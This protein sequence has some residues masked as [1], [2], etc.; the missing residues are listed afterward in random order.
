[1][2]ELYRWLLALPPQESTFASSIDKLHYFVITVTMLGATLVTLVGGVFILLYKR[3]GEAPPTEGPQAALLSAGPPSARTPTATVVI[4]TWLEVLVVGGLL[5][6]FLLWSIL[7]F[8]QFVHLRV[9]PEDALEVH[10]TGKKWMWQ[11]AYPGGKRSIS[12]LYV[13]AGRP[14]KLLM[15]SRDVIHSFFVPD[16]RAKWD[17]LPG[18]Y[19]TQWFEAKR[20]G[21]YQVLCTEYCGE[22]HSTMRGAVVALAPEEYDAWQRG[23]DT[24]RIPGQH[25]VEPSVVGD[26][27]E[28]QPI[29]M[30]DVGQRLAAEHGCLR[31]H[32]VDGSP[33]IAPTFA[34]MFGSTVP[35]DG[36]GAALADE[37]YLTESMMDPMAKRHEGFPPIMPSYLGRLRPGETAAILEYIKSLRHV[38]A[39]EHGHAHRHEP[40]GLQDVPVDAAAP[41]EHSTTVS[42]AGRPPP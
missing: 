10:V 21:T 34:S 20:A 27:A 36:G 39:E 13:P 41:H 5:G 9:P 16:F 22:G 38:P 25:Y 6:L 33:H 30:A 29:R 7:G 42:D 19:T 3:K 15:T 12:T 17:V 2:N 4:P 26:P 24:G 40:S 11:F 32:S 35:L 23:D 8:R 37:A 18:R 14:V 28:P 31:C 1:M